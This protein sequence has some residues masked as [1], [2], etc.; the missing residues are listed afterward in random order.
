MQT[1]F[2]IAEGGAAGPSFRQE[3]LTSGFSVIC[4]AG[5][6]PGSSPVVLGQQLFESS[7]ADRESNMR[8]YAAE[9]AR[10]LLETLR[11]QLGETQTTASAPAAAAEEPVQATKELHIPKGHA[12]FDRDTKTRED[13]AQV[14]EL[15][16]KDN[17]FRSLR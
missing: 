5:R 6:K 14:S 2:A 15:L 12:L 7:H 17:P 1:D 4:I 11:G 13:E 16:R 9:A 10:L 3:G 8:L